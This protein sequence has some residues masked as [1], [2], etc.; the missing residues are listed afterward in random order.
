MGVFVMATSAS[1]QG[2]LVVVPAAQDALLL[3]AADAARA[4]N[5]NLAE[6]KYRAALQIGELNIAYLGLARVVQRQGEC[7]TAAQLWDQVAT[8]PAAQ[9]PYPGPDDLWSVIERYRK[10]D[11]S[12]CHGTLVVRCPHGKPAVRVAGKVAA[13]GDRLDLPAGSYTVTA[14]GGAEGSSVTVQV[15][16]LRDTVATL[17]LPSPIAPTLRPTGKSKPADPKPTA[18]PAA[19]SNAAWWLIGTGAVLTVG[20]GGLAWAQSS[21]DAAI[22]RRAKA[23]IPDP[24]AARQARDLEDK[25]QRLRWAQWG[26]GSLAVVSLVAGLTLLTFDGEENPSVAVSPWPDGGGVVLSG[27]F[28]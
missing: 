8:A 3:E 22:S 9:P 18:T 15:I 19:S 1:A 11:A 2:A 21:N 17:D 7:R 14:A 4:G 13:C 23:G 26:T 6:D 27:A 28:P 16:G 25:G 10:D 24:A 20:T 12:L 5:L